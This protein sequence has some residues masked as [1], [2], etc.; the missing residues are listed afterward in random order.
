MGPSLPRRAALRAFGASQVGKYLPG[1]AMV[2]VIR[3]AMTRDRGVPMVIGGFSTLYET[4]AMMAS[5][6]LLALVVLAVQRLSAGT[7]SGQQGAGLWVLGLAGIVGLPLAVVVQPPVFSRLTRLL[8]LPFSVPAGSMPQPCRYSTLLRGLG[9]LAAGWGL[10]G[11]SMMA[12][13]G[14]VT[15]NGATAALSP[16]TWPV[17]TAAVGLATAAG[18]VVVV[19]PAGLGAREWVL[20]ETLTPVLGHQQ[21]VV[22]ALA[23]RLVCVVSEAVCAAALYFLARRW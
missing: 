15:G 17:M 11:L 14:A 19:M 5:G 7:P 16:A 9:L 23:L 10:I 4:T 20:F 1:K 8:T 21:A 6:A 22:A 12:S 3:C 2:I 13:A 18:F